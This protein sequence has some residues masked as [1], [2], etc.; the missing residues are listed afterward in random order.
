MSY[1][2]NQEA[3]RIIMEDRVSRDVLREI[4][5]TYGE[6]EVEEPEDIA[7]RFRIKLAYEIGV[8]DG[9]ASVIG[10][11]AVEVFETAATVVSN[12]DDAIVH[13]I[14]RVVSDE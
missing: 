10:D 4:V 9:I 6:A 11:H 14:V 3:A 7:A 1:D 13:D 2:L 5:Q 12:A 8:K